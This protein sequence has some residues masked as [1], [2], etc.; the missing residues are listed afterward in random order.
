MERKAEL[1]GVMHIADDFVWASFPTM[2]AALDHIV[3]IHS[4]HLPARPTGKLE[5]LR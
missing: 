3:E 2:R 4:A 1:F 5:W